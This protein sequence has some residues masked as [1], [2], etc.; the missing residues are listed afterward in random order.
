MLSPRWKKLW[1]DLSAARGRMVMMV[2]AIA[3]SIFGVGTIL[4]AYT[5]LMR[6][7]S[8]NYLGTSPASAFIE[9]N[10]VDDALVQAVR[11]QPG[12]ADAE[13]TSRVM[14]RVEVKPNEWMPML[15]F[16][17]PDFN[18]MRLSTFTSESGDWPPPE[19]TILLERAALP[20]TN[21]AV[22]DALTVQTP[23]GTKQ[24][25]RISGL[26]HDPGLAP[27][28]QEQTIYA[29]ITPATLAWLGEG[30]TLHILKVSV[31]E[32]NPSVGAIESTVSRLSAWLTG[33]GYAV[34]EIRIPPPGLHP[35][36]SQ[37]NSILMTLL[38]FSLMALVLSAILTATMIGG[39]LAQQVRQIGIMKAIGAR[40]SQVTGMYLALVAVLGLA[41]VALGIPAG[42]AAKRVPAA[43]T[44]GSENYA[45]WIIPCCWRFAT[46]SAAQDACS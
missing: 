43:S 23:N 41:A 19:Q 13:A 42:N 7:I 27:A 22:G 11:Q 20:L 26:A 25:I 14:G 16:V 29:Y 45:G 32:Q 33:Q 2:I 3:V 35:H 1:R 31:K 5:I 30:S 44:P 4:S 9:L 24:S 34:G 10:Q 21:V 17:I 15:L 28:W 40:S 8:R 12:I 46:P 6:E 38:V 36:Q 39:L 18:A 37:M